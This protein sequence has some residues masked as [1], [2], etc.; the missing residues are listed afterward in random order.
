M[1]EILHKYWYVA[2]GALVLL[3]VLSKNQSQAPVLQQV[4]GVDQNTLALASMANDSQNKQLDRQ[5]GFASAF[6]NYNLQS[7]QVDQI[8]PLAQM[9][10]D[11]NA[12]ALASQNQLAQLSFILQQNQLQ[13]Q[14][15]LQTKALNIQAGNQRR[16]DWLS[17]IG[18]GLSFAGGFFGI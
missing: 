1:K 14:A 10:S 16:Q 5:Y 2:L 7:R 6:L 13:S 17:L 8:I 18:T 15:D 11:A 9:Q 12:R 3:Y 4:G